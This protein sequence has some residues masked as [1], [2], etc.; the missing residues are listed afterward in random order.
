[1]STLFKNL[2]IALAIV[3]VLG[4]AYFFLGRSQ[5]LGVEVNLP[6]DQDI[7]IKIERILADTQS[8]DEYRI[9]SRSAI[10]SQQK[11]QSFVDRRVQISDVATGRDN[12]FAPV[13]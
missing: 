7:A 2:L 9:E 6:E 13:E 8:I 5:E 4:A 12:P 1:M 10:L 11:F 3:V